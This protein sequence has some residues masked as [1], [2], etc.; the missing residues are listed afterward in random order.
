MTTAAGTTAALPHVIPT[1]NVPIYLYAQKVSVEPEA[2]E[3]LIR[4]AESPL[5][6]CALESLS[7]VF[8]SSIGI[9]SMKDLVQAHNFITFS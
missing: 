4:L 6:V 3:Q 2:L 7:L 9:R 5:P 1:K 8:R